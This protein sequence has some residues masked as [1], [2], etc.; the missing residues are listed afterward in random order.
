MSAKLRIRTADAS[1]AAVLA[2]VGTRT[3]RDTFAAENAATDMEAYLAEAFS[4]DRIASELADPDNTFL[5][6]LTAMNGVAGYAKLRTGTGEPSVSGLAPIE[7][8][9]LYVDRSAIGGGFGAA[10]MEACLA[11]AQAGGFQTLWL[12]VWEHNARAIAFYQRWGFQ[13]VGAHE[14]RLGQDVQTDLIMQRTV[15]S[16]S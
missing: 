1:D 9:R 8:Q 4:L 13:Q 15:A 3:F 11:T 6:A 10:L 7:L 16:A 5:L 12:G 2:A 14:F